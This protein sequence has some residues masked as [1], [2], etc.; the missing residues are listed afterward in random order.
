MGKSK[1][2]GKI[3]DA[4]QC[5]VI[6]SLSL[7]G[8]YGELDFP[9]VVGMESDGASLVGTTWRSL[10]TTSGRG[11]GSR[12]IFPW[13]L[14]YG[15]RTKI[16]FSLLLRDDWKGKTARNAPV[17]S[18][19]EQWKGCFGLGCFWSLCLWGHS[20]LHEHDMICWSADSSFYTFGWCFDFLYV[21]PSG[22]CF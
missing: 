21:G 13:E 8:R 3:W 17:K 18:V 15:S 4:S 22:V 12:Y 14:A 11:H 2:C 7:G 20:A 9:G 10:H 5:C 16:N 1:V 6:K 19:L